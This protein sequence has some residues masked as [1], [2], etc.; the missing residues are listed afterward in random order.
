M[1]NSAPKIIRNNQYVLVQ[2]KKL[3]RFMKIRTI[4]D[5]KRSKIQ[6]PD[7]INSVKKTTY[8]VESISLNCV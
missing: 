4:S 1:T 2:Y 5:E 8:Y 6:I 7:T 3:N